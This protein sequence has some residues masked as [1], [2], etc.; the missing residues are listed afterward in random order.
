[1]QANEEFQ[2]VLLPQKLLIS[3]DL[4][5]ES[6]QKQLNVKMYRSTY[7]YVLQSLI[8]QDYSELYMFINGHWVDSQ[9]QPVSFT[10][11]Q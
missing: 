9:S 1:M 10:Q 8:L 2:D 5:Q 6:V 3:A 4:A 11:I 7:N